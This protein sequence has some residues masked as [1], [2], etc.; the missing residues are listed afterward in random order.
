[1]ISLLYIDDNPGMLEI[2]KFCIEADANFQV[3]TVQRSEDGLL[4][5]ASKEY[6]G[7]L[8]DLCMSGKD[9]LEVLGEVRSRYGD[10][11]LALLSTN[12]DSKMVVRALNEGADF[13]VSKGVNLV[14]EL[15]EVVQRMTG[16]VEQRRLRRRQ[17]ERRRELELWVDN[18]AEQVFCTD[19]QFNITSVNQVACRS[20]GRTSEELVGK[21]FGHL[22]NSQDRTRTM[23]EM[24]NFV[25]GFRS[26]PIRFRQE[27]A[28][29]SS[30]MEAAL[31]HLVDDSGPAGLVV[32]LR[33]VADQVRTEEMGQERSHRID[34][35]LNMTR[36]DIQHRIMV[37]ESYLELLRD[38]LVERHKRRYLDKALGGL[39]DVSRQI[40]MLQE[41]Q[42]MG[43]GEPRW[44]ELGAVVERAR[45]LAE[46]RK[47]DLQHDLHGL[48]V[49]ADPLL[50]SAL[51]HLFEME[52]APQLEA[53]RLDVVFQINSRSLSLLIDDDGPGI[54]V[55]KKGSLFELDGSSNQ[56]QGLNILREVLRMTDMSISEMG[57]PCLGR[58][59]EIVV[60][61]GRFRFQEPMVKVTASYSN[62]T[63][64]P[65]S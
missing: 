9:G 39:Q 61:E 17:E 65:A 24:E 14:T 6:D 25:E 45:G 44:I 8:V 50:E 49:L 33:E 62:N 16:L 28:S 19:Y 58:R 20:L 13:F 1:M 55:E 59:Y 34:M 36:H 56:S 2:V 53:S 60:P 21:P 52:L 32:S 38:G 57:M 35:V 30:W 46:Q 47:V 12:P 5:L 26:G 10:L 41:Y 4:M 29:S 27:R 51:T 31:S 18:I 63:A 7:V 64:R 48:E 11:P 43:R 22:V 54:A 23:L 3:D 42:E 15:D 40:E 37:A